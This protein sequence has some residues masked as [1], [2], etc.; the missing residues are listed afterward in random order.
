VITCLMLL[1]QAHIIQD[2]H[3]LAAL[4]IMCREILVSGL[5]EYLMELRVSLPVSTLAKFKT[6]LQMVA[7][8][9]LLS[10]EAGKTV[11]AQAHVIG[12]AL[13]WLAAALT[14]ITGYDYLR[15]GLEHAKWSE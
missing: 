15:K 4:I 2:I 6:T 5:R 7:L 9:F 1:V 13:L 10:D 11:I 14:L 3:F 8:G 12:L